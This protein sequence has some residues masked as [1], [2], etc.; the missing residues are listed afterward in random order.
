MV[1]VNLLT[2]E[3]ED[4]YHTSQDADGQGDSDGEVEGKP[5]AKAPKKPA[6]AARTRRRNIRFTDAMYE[7]V[8]ATVVVNKPWLTASSNSEGRGWT[9]IHRIL[10]GDS[11]FEGT[12][13]FDAILYCFLIT[14]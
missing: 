7:Q 10:L 12:L 9:Q 3:E 5:Q 8:I 14:I 2:G 1:V 11:R 6:A 13:C 4:T